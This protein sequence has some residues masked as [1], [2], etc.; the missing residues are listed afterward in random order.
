MPPVVKLQDDLCRFE[1]CAVTGLSAS[2]DSSS[3]RH[4]RFLNGREPK[5]ALFTERDQAH[6]QLDVFGKLKSAVVATDGVKHAA[7]DCESPGSEEAGSAW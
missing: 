7:P 4:E 1:A 5:C 6:G 3:K 2:T